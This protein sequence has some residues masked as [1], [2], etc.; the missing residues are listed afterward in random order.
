M[1]VLVPQLGNADANRS[2]PREKQCHVI[3]SFGAFLAF[4]MPEFEATDSS[5]DTSNW[6]RPR[7]SVQIPLVINVAPMFIFFES[8]IL[9]LHRYSQRSVLNYFYTI[10][11]PNRSLGQSCA[12]ETLYAMEEQTDLLLSCETLC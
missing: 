5:A 4:S 8:L 6:R 1:L 11:Y 7:S 2:N 10:L 9:L 12:F 3:N